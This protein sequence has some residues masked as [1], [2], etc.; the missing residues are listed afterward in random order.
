VG[1]QEKA[2]VQQSQDQLHFCR[3]TKAGFIPGGDDM[4]LSSALTTALTGLKTA[5]TQID[6]AGNNLANSQ[7]VGFKASDVVFATQFLRTLSKGSMPSENS[8]GTNPRQMGLGV[9][10]A[11]I[12]PDF[13]QGTIEASSGDSDLAIQGDGFFMVEGQQGEPLYTRNGIFK[14]NSQNELVTST[15]NRLLGFGID[16]FY[17]IQATEL[18]PLTIP[19]GSA[20]S[21]QATQNVFLSGNLTPTGDTAT[22]AEVIESSVLGDASVDR[23]DVT[24]ATATAVDGVGGGSGLTGSYSYLMTFTVNGAET[25]PSE[26]LGP[27]TVEDGRIDLANLPLAPPGAG[28]INIY[29]NLATDSNSY[30]FVGTVTP[31]PGTYS[32]TSADSAISSNSTIDLDGPK[33]SNTTLMTDI[34]KRDGMTY[35][36]MFEEGELNY[37]PRKGGNTLTEKTFTIDS[38]TTVAEFLQFMSSAS[39]VRTTLPGDA[40]YSE[41]N[42]PGETGTLIPG[43]S[44][45][46]DGRIR[47][48]S[49]NGTGNT[50]EITPAAFQETS[51][52]GVASSP[53]LGFTSVQDAVGQSATTDFIAY[54]SLGVPLDVRITAVLESRDD[55]TTTYR[56]FAD[57]GG[58]DPTGEDTAIAVGTGLISFD[59]EG[60]FLQADNSTVSIQRQD[61][62]S[63]HPLIFDLDFSELSGF[64]S[65]TSDMAATRQDGSSAGTLT[66]YSVG[67]DGLIIGV[68][69]NGIS[70]DL[71]QVRL[72]RFSNPAGL[73][74]RGQN[75]FGVGF[76][77]GLPMEGDPGALGLGS[78]VSGAVELSNTDI[79]NN[80]IDLL[81]ASTQYRAN[82]RVVSTSQELLDVLMNMR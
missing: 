64:A 22:A 3:A 16:E 61:I 49:N 37:S 1:E 30:H 66:S 39:G 2:T 46:S 18:V 32:D 78:I 68:F 15:G 14:T 57:S 67:E 21:A 28:E 9:Q 31:P 65:E 56:W 8:G 47:F 74:Q 76:N 12:T 44:I 36:P 80:L 45:T 48:V 52:S 43:G 6:V 73:E 63:T 55:T 62:P 38:G 7:T 20:A 27:I 41:N 72:A 51:D 23:A 75:L 25:R 35:V 4:G 71:G 10:V 59:G 50:I 33:I 58:N 29:R 42:I 17:N 13:T 81:L 77:S 5:E 53:D 24:G 69:S 26:L 60:S 34:V 54:D 79:G 40:G 11:E 19:M 82:S 70:R